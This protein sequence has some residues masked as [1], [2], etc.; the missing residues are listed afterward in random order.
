MLATGTLR[1]DTDCRD[2]PDIFKPDGP[3]NAARIHSNRRHHAQLHGRS[4]H[5]TEAKSTMT[6]SA[7][8][9]TMILTFGSLAA[10]VLALDWLW[11]HVRW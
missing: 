6:I 9:G 7:M 3:N 5:L 1:T 10:A 11:D 8:L 2:G 4:R